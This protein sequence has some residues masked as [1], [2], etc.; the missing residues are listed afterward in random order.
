MVLASDLHYAYP[1]SRVSTRYD[2]R[3]KQWWGRS[4]CCSSWD[5]NVSNAPH[6]NDRTHIDNLENF[7]E[8]QLPV[9]DSP[10]VVLRAKASRDRIPLTPFD[11]PPPLD[12]Y[13]VPGST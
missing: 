4:R 5:L 6:S 13:H 9:G 12:V 2:D 10:F 3:R 7:V 1:Q 8:A 11:L